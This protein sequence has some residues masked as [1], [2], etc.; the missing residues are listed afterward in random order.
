M[1]S[2]KALNGA[3]PQLFPDDTG[4]TIHRSRHL[5]NFTILSNEAVNDP[6]LSLDT[7]G[8]VWWLLAKPDH[9]KIVWSHITKFFGLGNTVEKRMKRELQAGGYLRHKRLHVQKGKLGQVQW[10][11]FEAPSEHQATRNAENPT[12]AGIGTAGR[13]PTTGANQDGTRISTTG[14]K[15]PHGA[16]QHTTD[17]FTT[18]VK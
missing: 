3:Q 4:P 12:G 8:L 15:Q 6:S 2:R 13:K 11:L 18:G 10:D 17:T 9:W 14:L 5:G 16:N 7:K 1:T